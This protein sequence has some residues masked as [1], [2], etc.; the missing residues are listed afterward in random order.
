MH[1]TFPRLRLG[2][3]VVLLLAL[4]AQSASATLDEGENAPPEAVAD[5]IL[6]AKGTPGDVDVLVNDDDPDDDPLTIVG[7]TDGNDGAVV[8]TG[9]ICVYTPHDPSFHGADSFTYTISDGNGG[10]DVGDV[11]VL[12]TTTNGQP[13]A[14]DDALTVDE[15]SFGSVAVLVNDTDPDE[16]EL[17]VTT[18]SP[19]AD[20]GTVSCTSE[21]TCTYTPDANFFGVDTFSYE[22]DDGQGGA[23]TGDVLVTVTALND[24]PVAVDDSL[25]V[26]EGAL[27]SLNVRT[28][29]TDADGDTL[30]VT[31][32]T[33]TASH[34]TVS[35]L[36]G[37]GCTYTPTAGYSGPDSFEYSISDGHGGTDTGTVAVTVVPENLP[38]VA[39]DE[40]LTTNEDTPGNV[41]VLVGDTDDDGDTLSV[42][43]PAPTAAHGTVACASGGL[44]T[45]TPEA[46]YS[47]SD[48]FAYTVSDGRGKSDTGEVS[49]T[50]TAVNDAPDAA[51][52]SLTTAEETEG[53]VDVL[54]NDSDIDGG[55]LTVTGS[56]NGAHGMVSCGAAGSC[57]YT[58]TTD[59][60]GADTFTY[61][62]SD[63]NGGTDT[64]TVSVTVT[65]VNDAPVAGDD[66][67]TATQDTPADLDVLDGDTDVDGDT[68]EVDSAGDPDHGAVTCDADSCT[69]T[70]DPGYLGADSFT[71]TVSDGELTDEGLVTVT[72]EEPN[73]APSC[74]G[75]KPS[76]TTL[77]PPERQFVLVTLFGAAD[78]D[79]DP[80][81][82]S[83][84][85]VKQDEKVKGI[86]GAVDKGPDA[87]R[88][89]GKPSRMNLRAERDPK[90]NGRVYRIAYTVSDGR[91]G[92]C[93]GVEKVGVPVKKGKKAVET[94]KSFN[95]L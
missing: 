29:D 93:T 21:G 17:T 81:T 50:V 5:D 49:V 66:V 77:W 51:A 10:T 89:S 24:A 4:A 6:T 28:N 8:C 16:D 15:D 35:C 7:W 13:E 78:A 48:S 38:P 30:I 20:H 71:Y 32:S 9:S 47:G 87:R 39:D 33:P 44:C 76:K 52:D 59:Y 14:E 27:G 94:A 85:S 2:L 25:T 67:V 55:A 31:T 46:N 80:L 18:A 53:T 3:L 54:T 75:V 63:G 1:A 90:A 61:T 83:I 74:A 43:T 34:G 26:D 72:V 37:G 40:T 73:A 23:D 57:D 65:Q 11:F 79:G 70:P 64:G 56:T 36:G 60:V 12:V 22:I 95:S 82:F 42:S 45:Y 88:V 58:P 69:Y 92:S 91:G 62:V 86:G 41:N 68:L 84:T 19:E